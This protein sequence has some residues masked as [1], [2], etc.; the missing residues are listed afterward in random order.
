MKSSDKMRD[1]RASKQEHE[2]AVHYI[3][4]GKLPEKCGSVA[5]DAD[6]SLRTC[7]AS[8]VPLFAF[9]YAFDLCVGERDNERDGG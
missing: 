8:F 1:R 6:Y 4:G 3:K 2:S 5:I 9:I 7:L